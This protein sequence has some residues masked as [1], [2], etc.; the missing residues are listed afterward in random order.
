MK[1]LLM[2][3]VC[4]AVAGWIATETFSGAT[5]AMMGFC[6]GVM[7]GLNLGTKWTEESIEKAECKTCWPFA[8]GCQREDK[9]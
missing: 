8:C 4:T 7:A 3:A 6:M 5:L 2:G 1:K 9:R